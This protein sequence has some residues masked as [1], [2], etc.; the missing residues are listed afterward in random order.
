MIYNH[1]ISLTLKSSGFKNFVAS[2]QRAS[3]P[4]YILFF[5]RRGS[6]VLSFGTQRIELSE[7]FLFLIPKNSPF[8]VQCDEP[9][10]VSV[11]YILFADNES[12]SG[13]PK[14]SSL[15]CKVPMMP[16]DS[17]LM[18]FCG[19]CLAG[20]IDLRNQSL[21]IL[22]QLLSR[23]A[24]PDSLNFYGRIQMDKRIANSLDYISNH[25]GETISVSGLAKMASLSTDYFSR[26]FHLALGMTPTHYLHNF[27][28]R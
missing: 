24:T 13:V 5:V 15:K 22:L 1:N 2:E 8:L 21:G 14:P 27:K 16:I 12:G 19:Q 20:T 10:G 28:T 3:C 4:F 26:L 9:D 17:E 23:F 11:H 7:G 18:S 25:A 6:G